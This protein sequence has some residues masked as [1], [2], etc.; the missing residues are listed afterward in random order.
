MFSKIMVSYDGSD[1]AQKAL[2]MAC[3]L[4]KQNEAK[5]YVLH[6]NVVNM[7]LKIQAVNSPSLQAVLDEPGQKIIGQAEEYLKT[8]GCDY[9]TAV[10]NNTSAPKPIMDYATEK[11]IDLIVMGSRG[12]GTVKQYFGSVSHAVLNVSKIPVLII[13]N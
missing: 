9:E 10:V 4:A 5:V 2:E 8:T 6:V 11:G 3:D 13:K 7:N 1:L 12:L